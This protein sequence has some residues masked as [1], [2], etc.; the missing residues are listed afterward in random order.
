MRI[1][2]LHGVIDR[3][4][5]VNLPVNVHETADRFEIALR[6]DDDGT[7]LRLRA[8]LAPEL[9]K[10]SVFESLPAASAFFEGGSLGYSATPDPRRFQG[11]ELRCL[12][13]QVEPLAVE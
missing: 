8:M 3:P 10:T 11:L 6:S 13:W 9:P 7:Q 4:I 1:P 12:Q 5:L 2:T